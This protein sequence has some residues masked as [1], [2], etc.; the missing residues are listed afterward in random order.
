MAASS[1]QH[2]EAG[3]ARNTL[4]FAA[5][6]GEQHHLAVSAAAKP[7]TRFSKCWSQRDILLFS[8][9]AFGCSV[10]RCKGPFIY[11]KACPHY[12]MCRV[13]QPAVP[14]QWTPVRFVWMQTVGHTDASLGTGLCTLWG[15]SSVHAGQM[16]SARQWERSHL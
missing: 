16:A 13:W 12:A 8:S 11:R 2:G 1:P 15:P 10:R 4:G 14:A 7:A 3:S 5:F 6:L 9:F